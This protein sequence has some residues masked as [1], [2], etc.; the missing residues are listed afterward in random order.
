[1][2][3]GEPS[4]F[5]TVTVPLTAAVPDAA[6]FDTAIALP[7]K[8]CPGDPSTNCGKYKTDCAEQREAASTTK[9]RLQ[10]MRFID[11]PPCFVSRHDNRNGSDGSRKRVR[12]TCKA[13]PR[14]AE[15]RAIYVFGG[16][17]QRIFI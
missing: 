17:R 12:K 1:M 3:N 11:L 7:Q 6:G 15:R 13:F 5:V 10:T 9:T 16:F 2:F 8:P 4:N 14:E